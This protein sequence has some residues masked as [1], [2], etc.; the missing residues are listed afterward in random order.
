MW[1][2][3]KV[4][5]GVDVNALR[6]TLRSAASSLCPVHKSERD[7]RLTPTPRSMPQVFTFNLC[8]FL[9]CANVHANSIPNVFL[10]VLLSSSS[11]RFKLRFSLLLRTLHHPVSNVQG[12]AFSVNSRGTKTVGIGQIASQSRIY[13]SPRVI[14]S[15]VTQL[16]LDC[17]AGARAVLNSLHTW[18]GTL[19]LWSWK[20]VHR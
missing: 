3:F 2:S 14:S 1:I 12:E 8:S 19:N 6:R 4:Y 10:I 20:P 13:K 17:S 18:L 16:T 9:R 11:R 7:I 15:L 5:M